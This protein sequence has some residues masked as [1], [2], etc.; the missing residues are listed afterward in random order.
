MFDNKESILVLC[1][2]TVKEPAAVPVIKVCKTTIILQ[3]KHIMF[4]FMTFLTLFSQFHL[5]IV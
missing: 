2:S 5:I 4:S 1:S 3:Y